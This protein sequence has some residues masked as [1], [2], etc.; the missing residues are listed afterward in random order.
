M[1]WLK[2][3]LARKRPFSAKIKVIAYDFENWE[4]IVY[5]CQFLLNLRVKVWANQTSLTPPLFIEVAVPNQES[6]RLC[7]SMLGVLSLPLSMNFLLDFEM[8]VS[9]M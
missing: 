7:N 3:V 1:S 6:D 2:R 4:K 5:Y 8:H 9:T